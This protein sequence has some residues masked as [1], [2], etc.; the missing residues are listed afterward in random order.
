MV[1]YNQLLLFAK[2]LH[3]AIKLVLL[4][5]MLTLKLFGSGEAYYCDYPL[6]GFPNQH[7]YTLLCYLVLHRDQTHERER[8]AATLWEVH[9]SNKPRRQLRN[10]L[11]RLRQVLRTANGSLENYLFVSNENLAF[12][13]EAEA[14]W[15]DIEIFEEGLTKYLD[16]AP[17]SFTSE[18]IDDLE[19]ILNLYQGDLLMGVYEDWCLYEREWLRKLYL[20]GLN[21]L[22]DYH[23]IHKNYEQALAYGRKILECDNVQERVHRRIMRLLWQSG[24]RNAALIQY[25]QCVQILRDELDVSPMPETENLYQQLRSNQFFTDYASEAISRQKSNSEERSLTHQA[26]QRLQKLKAIVEEANNE[27]RRLEALFRQIDQ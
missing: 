22:L 25:R 7:C 12:V 6:I 21:K 23:D 3:D 24:Q 4:N 2:S 5:K 8:L 15:L 17:Q 16:T 10:A 27:I 20:I 1:N 14:Y 18:Q 26:L 19:A 13:S 9:G 11:W